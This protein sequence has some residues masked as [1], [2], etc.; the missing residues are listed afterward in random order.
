MLKGSWMGLL[1]VLRCHPFHPGG[2]DPV[3]PAK[4]KPKYV[5]APNATLGGTLSGAR[6]YEGNT[7][8]AAD[9]SEAS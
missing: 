5:A 9:A 3:P 7:S 2:Y 6:N 4:G 1:R 8:A